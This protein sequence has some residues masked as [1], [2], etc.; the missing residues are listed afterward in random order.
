MN[1]SDSSQ[2]PAASSQQPAASCQLPAAEN[3]RDP[4][5]K[6]RAVVADIRDEYLSAAQTYP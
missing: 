4:V 1:M 6:F 3:D 5:E 2:Q